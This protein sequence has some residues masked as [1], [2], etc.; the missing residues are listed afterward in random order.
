VKKRKKFKRNIEVLAINVITGA[1]RALPRGVGL[2]VFSA[3]GLAAA[4]IFRR[5]RER[6]VRNLAVAFPDVPRSVRDALAAATFK[7]LGRNF[8]EFLKLEGSSP[9]RLAGLVD[10]IDG[11]EHLDAAMAQ[12]KGLIVITGH[13]G[14]WELLAGYFSGRG[15]RLNVVGRELWEKRMNEKLLR[16]RESMGYRTI[17]RDTGGKEVIRALR[18]KQVVAVLIDQHTR[19]SGVYVPFF[20]RPAHTP[21]GVAKLAVATGAPILPM[22]IYM[23]R[24]GRHRIRILP[25]LEMPAGPMG[26]EEQIVEITTRCSKAVE[27]LIRYDPKQWVWFHDRWREAEEKETIDEPVH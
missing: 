9:E 13:I 1:A 23:R 24:S 15:Y 22:A 2:R 27:E 8:Y 11:K 19:V 25:A 10:T 12:G 4:R 26:K 14:C 7:T 16:V 17:D 3:V 6:A 18:D 20:G 21:V 5:D